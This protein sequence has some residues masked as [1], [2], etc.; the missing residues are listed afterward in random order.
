[1][2][3]RPY[4]PSPTPVWPAAN[5]LM[6]TG[7]GAGAPSRGVR[8]PLVVT[9]NFTMGLTPLCPTT[10]NEKAQAP[11]RASLVTVPSRG[12]HS[13][14]VGRQRRPTG[15]GLPPIVLPPIVSQGR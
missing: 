2:G 1:M 12:C 15:W 13:L 6:Y 3:L 5:I 9:N 14:R 10:A 11:A 7:V 8:R 4:T